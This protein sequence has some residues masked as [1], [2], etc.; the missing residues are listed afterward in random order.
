MNTSFTLDP[1]LEKDTVT[2]GKSGI[3]RILLMK[4]AR[5]SWII[6]VPEVPG[7]TELHDLRESEYK[8]VM[9]LVYSLSSEMKKQL[10]A[11]KMNVGA[12]GNMVSQL[13][14]HIIARIK[15]DAAWPG[16]VWGSGA[17]VPYTDIALE[18]QIETL[19]STIEK[20]TG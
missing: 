5:F 18:K 6:L 19:K 1:R 8:D 11:D 16:P 12:L 10:A 9:S 14:I 4:D 7:L 13:H 17:A 3:C 20:I 2:I 15:D